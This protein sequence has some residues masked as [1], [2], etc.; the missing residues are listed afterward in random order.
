MIMRDFYGKEIICEKTHKICYTQREA[1]NIVNDCRKHGYK[2]WGVGQKNKPMRQYHCEYCGCW[3]ITHHKSY[4][5]EKPKSKKY[6]LLMSAIIVSLVFVSCS[7]KPVQQKADSVIQITD[8][9][10]RT[11]TLEKPAE[12]IVVMAD[13]SL[14]VVKQ[15]NAIEKV[16]A[17]DSKT[18]GYLPLSILNQTNPELMALPDVGK[19]K[20]PNYEYIISLSPD[21]ILFKGNKDT[22]DQ[23]QE[24]TNIPVACILSKG[25][26][27][28]EL[29]T[30]IGKLL[31]KEAEAKK[32]VK[33]F[34]QQKQTLEEITNKI[35]AE[36]KKNAY[37][38]VQ[39]SKENLFKTQKASV[40][41]SLSGITNV[42][43]NANKVDDWGFAEVSKEEFMNYNPDLIFLD[44]PVS[45]LDIQK[46]DLLSDATFAFSDA[47][48]QKRIYLTHT[49]SLPKDYV[50][51]IAEAYYYAH[52]A[53]PDL[54]SEKLY[55]GAINTIFANAYGMENYYESWEKTLY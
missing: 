16:V 47:A 55:R 23:L 52:K 46:E 50:Y 7:K 14:V 12:K 10:A 43:Q 33:M 27:D 8:Y 21:L 13:N 36:Q 48:K 1:G 51:V 54:I 26:Y 4:Y 6:K 20:S 42:A 44:M 53:Y 45:E 17:L 38:V 22:S 41:L 11:V 37:I 19:T 25:D 28:F 39:N 34:S 31:G 15:L 30:T 18:K 5:C 35:P 40:S 2:R 32:L 49:F 29:Y 9:A 3:H 24:K